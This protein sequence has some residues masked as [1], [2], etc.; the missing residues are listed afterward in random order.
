[1]S[2]NGNVPDLAALRRQIDEI[3]KAA[4]AKLAELNPLLERR[5]AIAAQIGELKKRHG[6][7]AFDEERYTARKNGL[8]QAGEELGVMPELV[9]VYGEATHEQAV[10][11]QEGAPQLELQDETD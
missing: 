3:D 9:E 1:M 2:E 10:N 5:K 7:P 8:V 11:I 4:L 6:R